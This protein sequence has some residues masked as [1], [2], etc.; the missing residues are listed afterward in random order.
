L[1]NAVEKR[2]DQTGY[3]SRLAAVGAITG[4]VLAGVLALRAGGLLVGLELFAYDQ[5][6]RRAIV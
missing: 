6:L 3:Q 1:E 2:A 5:M 4:L